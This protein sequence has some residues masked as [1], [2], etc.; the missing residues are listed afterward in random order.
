MFEKSLWIS[1]KNNTYSDK[2]IYFRKS[3]YVDRPVK[4]AIAYVCGL[5]CE[6]TTLNGKKVTDAVLTTPITSYEKR[7]LYSQY[8]NTIEYVKANVGELKIERNKNI[9]K[10][11]APHEVKLVLNDEMKILSAGEHII[12]LNTEKEI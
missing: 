11:F 8:I 9:C 10:I 4:S 3:I 1:E 6:E 2:S 7:V 12:L 5:G